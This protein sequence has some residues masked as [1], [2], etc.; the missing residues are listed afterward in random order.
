MARKTVWFSGELLDLPA[1]TFI[2]RRK[3]WERPQLQRA[4]QLLEEGGALPS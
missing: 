4:V 3:D 1:L 2:S